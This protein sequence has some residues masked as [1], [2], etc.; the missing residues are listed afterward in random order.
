[1][2]GLTYEEA[3]KKITEYRATNCCHDVFTY[4]TMLAILFDMPKEKTLND[5]FDAQK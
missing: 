1:M 3:V 5:L 2:N 4:S